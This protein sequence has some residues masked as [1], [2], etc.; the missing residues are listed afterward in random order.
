M[1]K[2]KYYAAR[3]GREGSKTYNSWDMCDKNVTGF[4]GATCKSFKTEA[5][6]LIWLEMDLKPGEKI[7]GA[8]KQRP[9]F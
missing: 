2:M 7:T 5:E 1:A 9:L 4:K 8:K 6:A 3:H